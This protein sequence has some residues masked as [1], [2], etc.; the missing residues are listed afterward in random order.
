MIPTKEQLYKIGY[1]VYKKYR[2][3]GKN[4]TKKWFVEMEKDLWANSA[5]AYI[6]EWEKI[7]GK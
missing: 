7:R 6:T 4:S 5:L 3:Y 1:K 2:P